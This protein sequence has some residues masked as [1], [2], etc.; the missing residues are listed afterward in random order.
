M[1]PRP[2]LPLCRRAHDRWGRSLSDVSMPRRKVGR[3]CTCNARGK[4]PQG[5]VLQYLALPVPVALH[6]TLALVGPAIV[7]RGSPPPPAPARES[8]ARRP[9]GSPMPPVSKELRGPMVASQWRRRCAQRPLRTPEATLAQCR[10][11][12][13]NSSSFAAV[14]ELSLLAVA[15]LTA[16]SR[17]TLRV[18]SQLDSEVDDGKPAGRHAMLAIRTQ[19]GVRVQGPCGKGRLFGASSVPPPRGP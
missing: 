3:A 1:R 14:E 8:P 17:A 2:L 15:K 4:K 19:R 13:S 5:Q 6:T 10:T 9:A 7:P 18:D 12:D 16:Q 11:G